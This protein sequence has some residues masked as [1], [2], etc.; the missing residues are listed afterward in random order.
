MLHRRFR[1]L[2]FSKTDFGEFTAA[3]M[4]Y[5]DPEEMHYTP[6][7]SCWRGLEAGYL[8]GGIRPE[9]V[10]V[11]IMDESSFDGELAQLTARINSLACEGAVVVVHFGSAAHLPLLDPSV[12]IIQAFERN[13]TTERYCAQ[14]LFGGDRPSGVLP[15]DLGVNMRQGTGLHPSAVRLGYTDPRDAGIKPEKLV[16]IHA[17]V[18]AAIDRGVFPACQVLVARKGKVVFSEGFGHHTYDS[19]RWPL[20]RTDDLFDIA[21]I[22]KVGATA[23]AM[24]RLVDDRKVDLSA[25]LGIFLPEVAK[26]PVGNIKVRDL[27]LHNSGLQAQMPIGKLYNYRNVPIRGCNGYFCRTRRGAY[28]VKVADGLYMRQ[29]FRDSILRRVYRLPV[30]KQRFR[31]SDVNYFLLQQLVEKKSGL[32]LDAFLAREL[33]GPLGLRHLRFRPLEAH[34]RSRVL[35]TEQDKRWRKTLVHGYPHDPAA[36]LM[37]G[38]GGNAGL[39]SNA[40]DLAVLCQLLL[41]RGTYG[42]RQYF[43]P[44]TVSGFTNA[45]YGNHRGLGFDTPVQRKYPSYSRHAARN[46]FGHTGFT[47]TCFWVDPKEELIYIFLSNR[48]HPNAQNTK[49]FTEA[50]RSRVHEIVYDALDTYELSLPKLPEQVWKADP[51]K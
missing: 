20:V 32:G 24:M 30:Y 42:G 26:R 33:Y 34:P 39:F 31:Y 3:F 9:E 45:S 8:P 51:A 25:R 36:A 21:S 47:G 11:V 37:G 13:K 48:V 14:L 41:N 17:V 5:A 4:K 10:L 28:Q 15:V 18:S 22:T 2:G 44:E 38:V 1:I 43:R 7:D 6:M 46:S 40:E 35:P 29:D 50:T 12:A 16:G 19:K 49:I 23:L 27:L